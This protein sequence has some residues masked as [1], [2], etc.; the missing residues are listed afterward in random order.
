MATT[1]HRL[2]AEIRQRWGT[3]ENY[4]LVL[5]TGDTAGHGIPF[6]L[7]R[8]MYATFK[9]SSTKAIFV[10]STKTHTISYTQQDRRYTT[11]YAAHTDTRYM[12][13]RIVSEWHM[14]TSDRPNCTL[15]LQLLERYDADKPHHDTNDS[16]TVVHLLE[17][18]TFA[19]QN[20]FLYTFKK[21]VQGINKER[22]CLEL[23]VYIV[24]L[25]CGEKAS[26]HSFLYKACDL[27]GRYDSAHQMSPIRQTF[28]QSL[29]YHTIL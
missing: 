22:A 4:V 10:P 16:Y 24:Q 1:L 2:L 28:E 26:T 9:H 8:S 3:H 18:W 5:Q 14:T 6:D 17:S 20:R 11:H 29:H 19:Y 27:F 25:Q 7:F 13:T 12:Y 15:R 21:S 23:P